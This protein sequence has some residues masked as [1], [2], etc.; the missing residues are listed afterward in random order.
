MAT[1]KEVADRA[2]VTVTTVSRMLNK[3]GIVSAQT[4]CKI[5][6]AMQELDYQPNELAR[7]LSKQQSNMIGL[8][9]PSARNYFFCKVIHEVEQA[10]CELGYK[11]LLCVSNHEKQKEIEYFSMLKANKVAGVLIASHTQ[12]LANNIAMDMPV[13]S[14]DRTLSPGIPSVCSDNENG[15]HLAAKLLVQ[16]GCRNLAY[17]SGSITPGMDANRR[18]DGFASELANHGLQPIVLE[19]EEERFVSMEYEDIIAAFF[20]R[21]PAVDGVFTSNDII[22]AQILRY[23]QKTGRPV[24]GSLK[25]VGYDD[26]ELAR[27]TPPAITTIR[28]DVHAISR[29]AVQSVAQCKKRPTPL[30]TV[31]PVTLI[32]RE[33]T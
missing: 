21:H 27:L 12:D 28:Q 4:T 9:V 26:I 2:G 30:A 18:Q 8:I 25:I 3:P 15:G 13:I 33:T 19:L 24:P 23:C 6:R 17:F 1:L 20:A 7:S 11:L 32:E 14:I 29:F 16:K 22:A 31:F 10:T 5:Q